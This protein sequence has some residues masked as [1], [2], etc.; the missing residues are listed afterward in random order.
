MASRMMP[1]SNC[2]PRVVLTPISMLSKSMNTAMF[3]R[4]GWDKESSY[5][6]CRCDVRD[7]QQRLEVPARQSS[8]RARPPPVGGSRTIL[9]HPAAGVGVQLELNGGG[10]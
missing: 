4:S 2:W 9:P 1:T 6:E 5:C 8:V 3:K 10:A 7:E